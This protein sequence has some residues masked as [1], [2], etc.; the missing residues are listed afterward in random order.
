MLFI[1]TVSIPNA[2]YTSLPRFPEPHTN[3]HTHSYPKHHMHTYVGN[4]HLSY[5]LFFFTSPF[6]FFLFGA[7]FSPSLSCV[8]LCSSFAVRRRHTYLHKS[9][10]IYKRTT[11][12]KIF[13][14]VAQSAVIYGCVCGITLIAFCRV[15]I[16]MNV[17]VVYIHIQHPIFHP[18]SYIHSYI[19]PVHTSIQA[20]IHSIHTS[21]YMFQC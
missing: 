17:Y 4:T 13:I 6:C 7:L 21:L 9:K 8:T 18:E 14:Y 2:F 19:H 20:Y 15:V 12:N 11:N 5:S 10:H 16:H 1:I 3:T